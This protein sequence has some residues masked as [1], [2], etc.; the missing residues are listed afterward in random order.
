[1][2][3]EQKPAEVRLGHRMVR[4]IRHVAVNPGCSKLSAATAAAGTGSIGRGWDAVNRCITGN[5][6]IATGDRRRYRLHLTAAGEAAE[7]MADG[8]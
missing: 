8:R 4:A 2:I 1:M 7:R 5:L 3:Q 6:I